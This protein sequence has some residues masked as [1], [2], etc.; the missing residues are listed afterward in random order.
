MSDSTNVAFEASPEV[1][2]EIC[3]AATVSGAQVSKPVVTS[4]P[5]DALDSPIGGDEI[6]Q[7]LELVIVAFKAG[8]AGLVFFKSL[9]DILKKHP[10]EAILVKDPASGKM[11]GTITQDTS[12]ADA[13]KIF[14]A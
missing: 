8:A 1:I 14:G 13:K 5:A 10:G 3:S 7:I 6:R 12:D 2:S 11:K 4:S 9:Q